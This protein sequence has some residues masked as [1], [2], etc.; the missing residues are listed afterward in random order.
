MSGAYGLVARA[1]L[2]M[3]LTPSSAVAE[4]VIAE[5]LLISLPR[6]GF[7]VSGGYLSSGRID[8]SFGIKLKFWRDDMEE[9]VES[10]FLES[11]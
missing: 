10:G 11:K 3:P 6:A 1:N 2:C 9:G 7:S 4:K 5:A 8:A